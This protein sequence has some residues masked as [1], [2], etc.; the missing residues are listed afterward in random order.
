MAMLGIL[1][2]DEDHKPLVEP[3]ETGELIMD[4]IKGKTAYI[5]GDAEALAG[6]DI[7]TFI[8]GNLAQL[9]RPVEEQDIVMILP[10]GE[11]KCKAEY[12]DIIGSSNCYLITLATEPSALKNS[13]E[14]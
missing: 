7:P 10:D 1:N 14:A 13:E 12:C 2:P 5:H 9:E 11:Y 3:K 6:Y 4:K 8:D